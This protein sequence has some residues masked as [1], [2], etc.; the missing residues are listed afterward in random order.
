MANI[1]ALRQILRLGPIRGMEALEP[2]DAELR[3]QQLGSTFETPRRTVRT[4]DEP[5]SLGYG[6]SAV[7]GTSHVGGNTF[8]P[9]REEIRDSGMSQLRRTLG[10]DEIEHGQVMQREQQKGEY[11]VAGQVAG[12]QAAMDRLIATQDGL[13]R[14]AA[15]SADVRRDVAGSR[16]QAAMER[17]LEIIQGRQ[18]VEQFRQGE[19]NRRAGV[20]QSGGWMQS[21]MGYLFGSGEQDDEQPEQPPQYTP[22]PT[23]RRAPRIISV[24]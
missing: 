18:S 9:S 15:D 12:Q 8:T 7:R 21:L 17:L 11:D 3:E 20:D 13:N 4:S 16:E 6:G 22:Q 23:G 2:S 14:R 5:W 10:L 19:M 24:E 1:D